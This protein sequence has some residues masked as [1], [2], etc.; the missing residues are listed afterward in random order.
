MTR[1]AAGTCL[2]LAFSLTIQH[3][4]GRSPELQVEN[5]ATVVMT[6]PLT[7]FNQDI[8][9][10]VSSLNLAP[11]ESLKLLVRIRNPTQSAWSSTGSY[12]ISLSYRWFEGDKMLPIEGAR[13]P[14]LT[15]VQPGEQTAAAAHVVAPER[16]GKLTLK[17]TLVQEGVTWFLFAGGRTFD[18]PTMVKAK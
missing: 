13:A 12:P 6:M 8:R 9:A 5:E 1:R 2:L 14:L 16:E 18:I 11:G 4:V 17:L 15:P 7:D 10:D 3:C